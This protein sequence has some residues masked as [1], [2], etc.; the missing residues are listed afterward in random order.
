MTRKCAGA[1]NS[2]IRRYTFEF[3]RVRRHSFAYYI[4]LRG[5]GAKEQDQGGKNDILLGAIGQNF[6][7]YLA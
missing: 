6:A 1:N 2:L 4:G 3:R 5:R 7:Y